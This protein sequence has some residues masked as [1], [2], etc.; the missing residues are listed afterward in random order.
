MVNLFQFKDCDR[1]LIFAAQDQA[2]NT[3]YYNSHIPDGTDSSC[4]LCGCGNETVAHIVSG[5]SSLAGI[6]YKKRHDAVGRRLHWCICSLYEFST[7]KEWW[8]HNPKPVEDS[9]RVKLLWDFTIIT[10]TNIC[11]NRPDLIL[12][13]KQERLAYLVDFSCPFDDN[14]YA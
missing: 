2:L 3:K 11:A 10:D 13:L 5:C 1:K 9:D 14:V 8:R 6:S 7:V 12:V 4:R